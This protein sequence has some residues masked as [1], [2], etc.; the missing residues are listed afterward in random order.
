MSID[1]IALS[2]VL[3][4]GRMASSGMLRRVALTRTDVSKEP[5]ACLLYLCS[6]CR[7]LATANVV[8]SSQI[9]VSLMM[10]ELKPSE[11]SILTRATGR[12]IPEDD[13]FQL[14]ANT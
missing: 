1:L 3:V 6:V 11:T 10:E 5:S 14:K 4:S 2:P 12:N 8:S 13:I 9:I 7:L